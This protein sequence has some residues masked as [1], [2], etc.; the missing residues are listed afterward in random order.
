MAF[1]VSGIPVNNAQEHLSKK[2]KAVPL[3]VHHVAVL[4]AR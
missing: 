3:L 4:T 1:V 2:T